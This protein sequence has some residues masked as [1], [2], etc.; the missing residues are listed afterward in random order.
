MGCWRGPWLA[1]CR[2]SLTHSKFIS[3]SSL[4]STIFVLFCTLHSPH[5]HMPSPSPLCRWSVMWMLCRFFMVGNGVWAEAS[6]KL[7][8]C[9][10][11]HVPIKLLERG[12][13]T[14]HL[15]YQN[16]FYAQSIQHSCVR[17]CSYLH[18]TGCHCQHA[19]LLCTL[20]GLAL[21]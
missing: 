20:L 14:K 21:Y 6:L 19:G 11:Q 17:S 7:C 5:N 4:L 13:M 3:W 10:V 16:L 12:H 1:Y 8:S 9:T 15:I 18:T 2:M